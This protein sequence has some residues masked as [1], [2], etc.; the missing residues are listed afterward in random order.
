MSGP[1][2]LDHDTMATYHTARSRPLADFTG[3]ESLM[4]DSSHAIIQIHQSTQTSVKWQKCKISCSK[5]LETCFT[6]QPSR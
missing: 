5:Y 2:N 1:P 3:S 6:L 4:T